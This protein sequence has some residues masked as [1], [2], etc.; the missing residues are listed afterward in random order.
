MVIGIAAGP[1]QKKWGHVTMQDRETNTVR[2]NEVARSR[3]ED[4]FADIDVVEHDTATVSYYREC[5]RIRAEFVLADWRASLT[6]YL[7][8]VV[9]ALLTY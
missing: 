5:A 4:R 3:P 7:L 1:A 8:I 9:L 2:E 6:A